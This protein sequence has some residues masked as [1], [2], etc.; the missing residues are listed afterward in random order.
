MYGISSGA[1]KAAMYAALYPENLKRLA[2]EAFVWTGKDSP[3]LI[4]RAKKLPQW[5][6]ALRRPITREDLFRIFSRDKEG[7]VDQKNLEH[8][9]AAVLSLDDSMPNGTYVDMCSKL[10]V[11]NPEAIVVPTLILRGEF[12]GIAT[13]DDVT[14]FF[15]RISCMNK[16][17]CVLQDVGHASLQGLNSQVT[18]HLL[19]SFFTQPDTHSPF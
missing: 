14:Q 17:F 1:L 9:A 8:F 4:E 10:P 6:G 7:L 15:T 13:L 3:T 2:L 5:E 18:Y 19:Y 11:V 16:Q 12:D